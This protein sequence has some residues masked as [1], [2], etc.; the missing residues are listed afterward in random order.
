MKK[1][2][3]RPPKYNYTPDG[4]QSGINVYFAAQDKLSRPYTIAGLALHLGFDDRHQL[5]KH[6]QKKA[7]RAIINR[8][9]SRIEAQ[10]EDILFDKTAKNIRGAE[11]W[12]KNHGKYLDR[13]DLQVSGGG[14]TRYI[15]LP[16]KKPVGAEVD[17]SHGNMIGKGNKQMLRQ[18]KA[19]KTRQNR[20][21]C[22]D[23]AK[24]SSK[25]M[26][27]CESGENVNADKSTTCEG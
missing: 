9:R 12:L 18:T 22:I 16:T 3:G 7:F 14:A 4:I 6:G 1:P 23:N 17:V 26:T 24:N 21:K 10:A 19:I 13:Q 20:Q 11:F 8:A 5:L 2:L 15:R 25:M 27:K